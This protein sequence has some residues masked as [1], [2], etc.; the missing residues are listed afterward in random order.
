M[1]FILLKAPWEERTFRDVEDPCGMSSKNL[2]RSNGTV[3]PEMGAQRSFH[4]HQI[5]MMSVSSGRMT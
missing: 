5:N 2:A 3:L 4:A 1:D